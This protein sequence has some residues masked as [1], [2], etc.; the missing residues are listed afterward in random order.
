[1]QNGI[2]VSKYQGKV[3]WQKVKNAGVQFAM[4]RAGF[5]RFPS[6]KDE[7]FEEN[8]KNATA[9]GVPVGA[10]HYSYAKSAA[11]AKEEARVFL[12]WIEGKQF[13]YP[14]AYDIEEKA[15]ADLGKAAVSDIIRAFCEAV[16]AA[17]C[18]VCIYANKFFLD[19]YVDEDCKKRYDVWV[20]QWAAKNTYDGNYGM[21]QYSSSGTVDGIDGRVDLDY[22]YKDYPAIMKANGLNGVKKTSAPASGGTSGNPFPAKT[23]VSLQNTPLYVSATAKTPAAYKSGSYYIYDGKE[24]SGRYRITSSPERVGKTP[25][26]ENVTGY[27]NK[28][29]LK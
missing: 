28:T 4:L 7:C 18:Y 12:S 20:A 2:D 26:G 11:D 19:N 16:E 27:V 3:D 6:Q 24:I 8:Y 22:A 9:A 1:M 25:I 10:Y 13:S 23:L 14:V 21:W 5:G 29:D 15:Q 17:G